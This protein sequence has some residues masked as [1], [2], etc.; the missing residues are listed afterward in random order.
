[1]IRHT[2]AGILCEPGDAG[3][4]A[5]AI[6]SLLLDREQITR[7]SAAARQ[8]ATDHFSMEKMADRVLHLYEELLQKAAP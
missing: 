3:S 4:L 5:H 6:Q 1:L 2:G 7:M 8:A